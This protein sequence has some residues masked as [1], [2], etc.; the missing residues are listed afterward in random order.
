MAD[1]E[2][3]WPSWQYRTG[4]TKN[5]H[6]LGVISSSY[7]I[8]ES[9][10]ASLFIHHFEIRGVATDLSTGIYWGMAENQRSA[11]ITKIFVLHEKDQK[12]IDCVSDLLLYF[13]WC[14]D[15]RNKLL[16]ATID[17]PLFGA[18][19]DTLYLEAVSKG[20]E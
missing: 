12:T 17:A 6:A 9:S 4:P 10:L 18:K 20:V 14:K 16:H 7:N 15:T 8:F 11:S 19:D 5:L 13:D 2:D 3:N 1:S